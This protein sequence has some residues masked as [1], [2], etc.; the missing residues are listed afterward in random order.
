[1]R[2]EATGLSYALDHVVLRIRVVSDA[3]HEHDGSP[4]R[5]AFAIPSLRIG[6]HTTTFPTFFAFVPMRGPALPV[7]FDQLTPK[8][9]AWGIRVDVDNPSI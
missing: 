5:C 1:M 9:N 4:R 6:H 3:D 7:H 2:W 8:F